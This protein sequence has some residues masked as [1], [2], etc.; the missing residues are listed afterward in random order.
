M[1]RFRHRSHRLLYD[2]RADGIVLGLPRVHFN[3]L[4]TGSRTP[5]RRTVLHAH[6]QPFLAVCQR[7]IAGGANGEHDERIALGH[8]DSVPFLV[9]YPPCAQADSEGLERTDHRETHRHSGFGTRRRTDLHV[10]RHVL[11]LG[12]RGRGLCLFLGVHGSRFLAHFKVGRPRRRASQRPLAGAHRLYDGPVDWRSPAE[13]ALHSGHRAGLLLPPLSRHRNQGFAHRA[14]RV[15]C[16]RRRRALRRCS[17]H[18][19]RR[20]MV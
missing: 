7:P 9:D 17:R 13:F 14:A 10:Q 18:H 19:H 15:V 5:A 2:H 8:D 12:S 6:R 4:Q 3:W 11:V 20:R 16:H 1:V